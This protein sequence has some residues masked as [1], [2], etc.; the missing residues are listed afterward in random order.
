MPSD[1]GRVGG[2]DERTAGSDRRI[3]DAGSDG[4]GLGG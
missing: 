4:H 2:T 3:E 1:D